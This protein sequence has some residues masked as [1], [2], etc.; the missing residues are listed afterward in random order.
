[1]VSKFQKDIRTLL[2]RMSPGLPE[3]IIEEL[4]SLAN[5]LVQMNNKRLV[6][7]NHSVME[8]LCARHL[9][10]KGY[11]VSLEQPVGEIL[12]CDLFGVKGD[13]RTIVE[14][15]TGYTPP[16]HALDPQTYNRA[17]VASKIARYSVYCDKFALGVPPFHLLDI[18]RLFTKPPRDRDPEDVGRVKKLCDL[19]YS[20]PPITSENITAARLHSLYI[21]DVDPH[22]VREI[23]PEGYRRLTSKARFS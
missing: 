23:D 5:R 12:V 3:E 6:K 1:M 16:S 15:E 21:I 9:L 18:P 7:I 22:V 10:L 4:E 2:E 8:L 17:R 11:Q 19:Y 20:N 13:G 14:V